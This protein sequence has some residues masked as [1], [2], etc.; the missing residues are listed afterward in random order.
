MI[1]GGPEPIDWIWKS[2]ARCVARGGAQASE[3][4]E[5]GGT[6]QAGE[7]AGVDEPPAEREMRDE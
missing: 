6:L 3:T 2:G 1:F 7:T 4:F 5:V